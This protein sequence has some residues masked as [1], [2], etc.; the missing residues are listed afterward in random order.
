MQVT[1]HGE[2]GEEVE[3]TLSGTG[4]IARRVA[5]VIHF[6]TSCFDCN[7]GDYKS[8]ERE[9]GQQYVLIT[10]CGKKIRFTKFK[11]VRFGRETKTEYEYIVSPEEASHRRLARLT[12]LL[13]ML[14]NQRIMEGKHLANTKSRTFRRDEND[15]KFDEK[16]DN[17]LMSIT[18]M[19][20]SLYRLSCNSKVSY[21]WP[22]LLNMV[23][24]FNEDLGLYREH[25]ALLHHI[26]RRLL[27]CVDLVNKNQSIQEPLR[28][29][30]KSFW[31]QFS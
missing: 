18:R 27:A 9:G 1:L 19:V 7:K 30:A 17:F 26:M 4:S 13:F 12:S 3:I 16:F 15:S 31:S 22:P 8:V 11:R 14:I 6:G 2:N 10:H 29:P 24:G 21:D 25:Q 28:A 5:R 23:K 20:N